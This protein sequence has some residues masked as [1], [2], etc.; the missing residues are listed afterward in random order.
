MLL[1]FFEAQSL[2]V[3]LPAGL[4]VQ[5]GRFE[6]IRGLQ[7]TPT[8][9]DGIRALAEDDVLWRGVLLAQH[10]PCLREENGKEEFVGSMKHTKDH[11]LSG[12]SLCY[13]ATLW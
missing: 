6:P 2:C 10:I 12:H 1:L 13:S 5:L 7:D 9:D 3:G 8:N 11:R 4:P